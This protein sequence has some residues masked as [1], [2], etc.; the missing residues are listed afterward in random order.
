M[1]KMDRRENLAGLVLLAAK[2]IQVTRVLMVILEMLES[3]V[4]QALWEI[5]VIEVVQEDQVLQA[6]LEILDQ[7]E[8]EEVLDRLEF[9]AQKE[10][11]GQ[12][13]DLD[14]KEML[15][16]EEILDLKEALDLMGQK[17]RRVNQVLRDPEVLQVKLAAKDPRVITDFQDQE[18]HQELLERQ[19]E[20]VHQVTQVILALEVILA[21]QDQRV[22]LADLDSAILDQE[23]QR[24]TGVKKV[25]LD[26]GEA[27]ETVG[28]RVT[29]V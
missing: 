17:E 29:Q 2:V 19:A 14:P 21:L 22:I 6:Q 9:L 5:R 11:L 16:E 10:A 15:G 8:R 28:Q 3:L 12:L 24:V 26:P 1:E 13:E 20:R 23:D 4:F 25:L 18:A 27:E 7:K